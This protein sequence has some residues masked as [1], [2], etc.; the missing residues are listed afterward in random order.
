MMLHVFLHPSAPSTAAHQQRCKVGRLQSIATTAVGQLGV[1]PVTV[2]TTHA[3]VGIST[4][5][6][7]CGFAAGSTPAAGGSPAPMFTCSPAPVVEERQQPQLSGRRRAPEQTR[8]LW[9]QRACSQSYPQGWGNVQPCGPPAP[10]IRKQNTGPSRLNVLICIDLPRQQQTRSSPCRVRPALGH[11]CAVRLGVLPLS[12]LPPI[13]IAHCSSQ[14]PGR[15]PHADTIT[16][17][18]MTFA[19]TTTQARA[20]A[21]SN[22][23]TAISQPSSTRAVTCA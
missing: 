2:S 14:A 12:R 19:N 21:S 23:Y 18:S 16:S 20:L 4:C 3:N 13:S 7:V 6:W 22:R 1:A 9:Y 15:L 11:L 17:L 8:V 5:K 10:S